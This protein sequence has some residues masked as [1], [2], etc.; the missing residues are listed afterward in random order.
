M[1]QMA[2]YLEIPKVLMRPRSSRSKRSVTPQS[3]GPDAKTDLDDPP[4]DVRLVPAIRFSPD[5]WITRLY[6]SAP[7]VDFP[8][9]ACAVRLIVTNHPIEWD[10]DDYQQSLD[11]PAPMSKN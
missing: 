1:R 8:Q 6:G 11:S 10:N 2:A 4:A 3:A 9:A 7:I 5:E